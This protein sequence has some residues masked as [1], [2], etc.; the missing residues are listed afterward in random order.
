MSLAILAGCIGSFSAVMTKYFG[1]ITV[2][3]GSRVH[4]LPPII[5][6]V[7]LYSM[8]LLLNAAMW[9]AFT[10]AL[11]KGQSSTV[12]SGTRLA[13]GFL[14]TGIAGR[15]IFSEKIDFYWITGAFF[16]LIGTMLATSGRR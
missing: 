9:A 8:V 15:V 14:F 7:S 12:T 10:A 11:T 4:W 6:K 16:I 2:S 3:E 1:E 13:S 5:I